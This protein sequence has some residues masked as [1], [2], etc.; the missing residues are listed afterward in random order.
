MPS[1]SPALPLADDALVDAV[2]EGADLSPLLAHK[3]AAALLD[4]CV[5]VWRVGGVFVLSLARVGC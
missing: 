4:R 3:G 1:S 2:R 5:L